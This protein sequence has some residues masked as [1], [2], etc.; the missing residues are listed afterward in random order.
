MIK[1]LEFESGKSGHQILPISLEFAGIL[2][3]YEYVY[4]PGFRVDFLI[5][6]L[7]E[8]SSYCYYS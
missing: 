2:F 6:L 1:K 4:F 5:P 3:E 7:H 8:I